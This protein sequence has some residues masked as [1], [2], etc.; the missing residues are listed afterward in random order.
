MEYPPCKNKPKV[1]SHL[2]VKIHSYPHG[3]VTILFYLCMISSKF[4]LSVDKIIVNKNVLKFGILNFA[5]KFAI[6]SCQTIHEMQSTHFEMIIFSV[7][8]A[9]NYQMLFTVCS[10]S[11]KLV[12]KKLI[13]TNARRNFPNSTQQYNLKLVLGTR[14]VQ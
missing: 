13:Q 11:H 14:P 6:V 4:F 9:G 3:F 12:Q 10:K 2:D 5:S 8:I 7:F 1:K